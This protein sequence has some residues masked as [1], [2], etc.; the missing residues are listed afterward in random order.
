MMLQPAPVGMGQ[1]SGRGE[2]TY[3][4]RGGSEDKGV[5]EPLIGMPVRG[6]IFYF[7]WSHKNTY[8]FWARE[9]RQ[10]SLLDSG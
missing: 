4:F 1:L 6:L 9:I 7:A 8:Y 5:A 3:G 2:V 10:S